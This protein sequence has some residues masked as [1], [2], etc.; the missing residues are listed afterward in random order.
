M[1]LNIWIKN[2]YLYSVLI[3][4][5]IFAILAYHL[6]DHFFFCRKTQ[7]IIIGLEVIIILLAIYKKGLPTWTA[8]YI[9]LINRY[10]S[11][12]SAK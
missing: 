12:L 6:I 7:G 2:Y 8:R 3:V 1:V 11:V 9:Y 5:K 4:S 10:K